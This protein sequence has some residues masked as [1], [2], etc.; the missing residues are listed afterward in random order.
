MNLSDMQLFCAGSTFFM[1][2]PDGTFFSVSALAEFKVIEELPVGAEELEP[3][4][5]TW[6]NEPPST[7]RKLMKAALLVAEHFAAKQALTSTEQKSA[8]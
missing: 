4:P 2:L 6:K 7:T 5:Y 1:K 3:Y 8:P